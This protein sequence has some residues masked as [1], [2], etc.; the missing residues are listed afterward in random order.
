[1]SIAHFGDM[2]YGIIATSKL[3]ESSKIITI[4]KKIILCYDE[5]LKYD[6]E[7]YQSLVREFNLRK[8]NSNY[9]DELVIAA[10]LIERNKKESSI[11]SPYIRVLPTH[12]PNFIHYDTEELEQLQDAK[13]AQHIIA[14][15]GNNY[16]DY[17]ELVSILKEISYNH[18]ITYDD[19]KWASSVLD[20]RGLRFKGRV[21]LAPLADM[22]NYK[23]HPIPRKAGNGNFFLKHHVLSD[24]SLTI[25]ADRSAERGEQL[26]E[27][28]GDNND[29]IY[30]Q[31]HGFIP[32]ENPFRC[33]NLRIPLSFNDSAI[34]DGSRKIQLLQ[35]LGFNINDGFSSCVDSTGDIGFGMTIIMTVIALNDDEAGVCWN[36]VTK[37]NAL[38]N[39]EQKRASWNQMVGLDCNFQAVRQSISAL[40]SDSSSASLDE[41]SLTARV[42]RATAVYLLQPNLPDKSASFTD[43]PQEKL[44]LATKYREYMNALWERICFLYKVDAQPKSTAADSSSAAL[45]GSG[46]ALEDRLNKFNSWFFDHLPDESHSKI[47]AVSMPVYRIGTI[48]T[49]DIRMD[50]VYLKVPTAIIMDSAKAG[51]DRYRISDLIKKLRSIYKN[52]DDF[53]ELLFLLLHEYH[54]SKES[55]DFYPYLS[56]LPIQRELDVPLLWSQ[57]ELYQ[58]LFPSVLFNNTLEYVERTRRTF[59]AINNISVIREYFTEYSDVLT[60]SNYFWGTVIL[61]SRSIWW[62]G[63]RHLVPMLD[64]VNCYE[65]EDSPDRVHSTVLDP[66]TQLFASTKSPQN[67]KAQEQ[68]FE[69]YGQPNHIYFAYHGFTLPINS[70][71]C[72][73]FEIT[74]SKEEAAAVSPDYMAYIIPKIRGLRKNY[75]HK[76]VTCITNPVDVNI[77][78]YIALKHNV[79]LDDRSSSYSNLITN[80]VLNRYLIELLDDRIVRYVKHNE[81]VSASH[82]ASEAFLRSELNLLYKIKESLLH[83]KHLSHEDL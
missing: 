22:F 4:P 40:L 9:D 62:E 19:Y 12:V 32:A 64:F 24:K 51:E 80:E 42:L 29:Q 41:N 3:A 28:Y 68:L 39:E 2:G 73:L 26:F 53:H 44:Q 50:E 18:E 72:V 36:G 43:G 30:S 82:A 67:I 81:E 60:E 74:I 34:S 6:D 48:A 11:F 78:L 69:N 5:I 56:V 21:H 33:I 75:I 15:N 52:S 61:D 58:R 17:L 16:N 54:V 71:D 35:A 57:E 14:T 79:V 49:S 66:A 70:H 63:K 59:Q 38:Q 13:F 25:F 23:P 76:F 31:Y 46:D 83:N 37:F 47:K 1:M 45:T 27:D 55:S 65:Y 7:I 20:S 77:Y 10:L 8:Q